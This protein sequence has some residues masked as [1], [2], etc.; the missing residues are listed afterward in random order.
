M[1]RLVDSS[2]SAAARRAHVLIDGSPVTNSVDGLSVYIVNLIKALPTIDISDFEF[3]ILLNPGV[4]WPDLDDAI[5]NAGFN[6]LRAKIASIGPRREWDMFRFLKKHRKTFDLIHVPSNNYPLALRGGVCTICDIT[7]LRWIDR[8]SRVPG[9]RWAARRF[10]RTMV[11]VGLRRADA[12]IAI[13]KATRDGLIREFGRT[14]KQD[15]TVIYLGWEHLKEYP[16]A[17]VYCHPFEYDGYLLFLGSNRVHKNLSSLLKAFE[18]ASAHI[19]VNKSLVISGLKRT[20]SVADSEVL[21]RVNRDKERIFFTGYISNGQ[22]RR[23]YEK[24]DAFVFP[25][26]S[27]GFG[28]PILEAFHF[29]APLLCSSATCLPEVAGD[30]ALYFDPADPA[31]IADCI[32]KFY[33]NPELAPRL[34]AA[35]RARIKLFSWKITASETVAIYRHALNQH[36]TQ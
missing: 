8:K 23:L 7:Y 36:A 10:L 30:A 25:S 33:Q 15:I 2:G 16:D 4:Q 5:K 6:E 19:P 17:G 12:V 18:L 1:G 21:A 28:L 11:S 35:G 27:E 14:S 31:S 9:W 3:T 24:A 20:L 34:R 22:V 29:G 32:T 26:F 13:S